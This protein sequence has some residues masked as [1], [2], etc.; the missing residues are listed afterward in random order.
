MYKHIFTVKIRTLLICF[1]AS[2]V[3]ACESKEPVDTEEKKVVEEEVVI[4]VSEKIPLTTSSEAAR[5]SLLAGRALMDNLLFTD[6]RPFFEKAVEL[7]PKFAMGYVMLANSAQS[8]AQFFDA[9]KKAK[10]NASGAS[11]GEKLLI[12]ALAAGAS[13]DQTAQLSQP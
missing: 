10:D 2:V 7:D 8:T 11:E 9:L 13:N 12:S 5:E 3:V 4:Q 6:S 1:L